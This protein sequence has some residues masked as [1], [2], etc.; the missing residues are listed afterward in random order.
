MCTI[1]WWTN[2]LFPALCVAVVLQT[3]NRKV[4]G[5]WVRANVRNGM[6]CKNSRMANG[7]IVSNG[8]TCVWTVNPTS[9]FC[10]VQPLRFSFLFFVLFKHSSLY[11]DVV[12]PVILS[13]GFVPMCCTCTVFASSTMY[14]KSPRALPLLHGPMICVLFVC[15]ANWLCR[16]HA[17]KDIWQNKFIITYSVP[18]F[19]FLR[20]V[21]LKRANKP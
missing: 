14:I 10:F 13:L 12:A 20:Q 5:G 3:V 19:D 18:F 4:S 21:T 17:W 8:V 7:I 6:R 15:D 1:N 11:C 16:T 2:L 9:L